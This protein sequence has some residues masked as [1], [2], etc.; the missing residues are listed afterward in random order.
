MSVSERVLSTNSEQIADALSFPTTPRHGIEKDMLA[1]VYADPGRHGYY[2][3]EK[4]PD[5]CAAFIRSDLVQAL[6]DEAIE[7]VAAVTEPQGY[8]PVCCHNQR[9][10]IT[11]TIRA[12]KGERE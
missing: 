9:V 3:R 6:V 1:V 12:M 10:F 4:K 7:R 2:Y 5:S 11:Q 8:E